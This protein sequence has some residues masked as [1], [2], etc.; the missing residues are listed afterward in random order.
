MANPRAVNVEE[1]RGRRECYIIYS[2][3]FQWFVVIANCLL[4]LTLIFLT[5]CTIYRIAV[6]SMRSTPSYSSN[7]GGRISRV[8]MVNW[9]AARSTMT[10][11]S[12][13]SLCWLMFIVTAM[14]NTWCHQCH[15]REVTWLVYAL[16]TTSVLTNPII[17]SLLNRRVRRIIVRTWCRLVGVTYMD[18]S[19]FS[20]SRRGNVK[21]RKNGADFSRSPA[22]EI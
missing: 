17:Y 20:K 19:S 9:R 13:E 2:I 6:R 8:S 18:S 7:P 3:S 5:N 11:T 22:V 10:V 1:H 4:P 16:N 21:R 12:N 14:W 15:P